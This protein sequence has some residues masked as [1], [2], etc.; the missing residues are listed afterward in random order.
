MAKFLTLAEYEK[1]MAAGGY[2]PLPYRF[3][4]LSGDRYVLTNL[5]GEFVITERKSLRAF[6]DGQLSYQDELYNELKSKHFLIDGDSDVALDLLALKVRT[7]LSPLAN[8]TAC[9]SLW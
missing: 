4:P 6:A 1:P 8:F 5:V 2:Q 9:I 7:K 3:M